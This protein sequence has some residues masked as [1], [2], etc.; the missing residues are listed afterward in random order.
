MEKLQKFLTCLNCGKLDNDKW[1]G[2]AKTMRCA[3]CCSDNDHH[4]QLC[5]KCC[6]TG[7]GTRNFELG[8]R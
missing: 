6:V 8:K 5:R 2:T 7:H 4:A 1:E 3:D